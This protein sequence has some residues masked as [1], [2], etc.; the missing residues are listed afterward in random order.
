MSPNSFSPNASICCNC[1]IYD[2]EWLRAGM[3]VPGWK[4]APTHIDYYKKKG[5]L[6]VVECPKMTPFP[7][8]ESVS[9]LG[10]ELPRRRYAKRASVNY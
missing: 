3:P 9:G 10:P 1:S 4:T 6:Q 2:C 8:R 7:K 5:G